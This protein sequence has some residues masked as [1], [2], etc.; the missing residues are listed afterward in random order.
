MGSEF[1]CCW[2]APPMG[3]RLATAGDHGV[4]HV[5]HHEDGPVRGQIVVDVKEELEEDVG[6][7]DLRLLGNY[8]HGFMM[9]RIMASSRRALGGLREKPAGPVRVQRGKS[10]CVPVGLADGCWTVEA[11]S[12]GLSVR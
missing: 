2:P 7:I 11:S 3:N 10:K 4:E 1:C 6:V 12:A 8:F 5:R 9:A